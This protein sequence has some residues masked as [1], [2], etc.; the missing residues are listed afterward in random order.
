MI[1]LTKHEM[2]YPCYHETTQVLFGKYFF[3]CKSIR[4][5]LFY[6]LFTCICGFANN[7]MNCCLRKYQQQM[8]I[9]AIALHLPMLNRYIC[10]YLRIN[11]IVLCFVL[12][13]AK[14]F[15]FFSPFF[16]FLFFLTHTHKKYFSLYKFI[17]K[18]G[19]SRTTP[20]P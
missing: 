11:S 15:I 13:L 9:H 7:R 14:N 4:K 1:F 8:L 16:L 19:G 20:N 3:V 2:M 17:N 18:A 6:L 12:L 5:Y 10:V